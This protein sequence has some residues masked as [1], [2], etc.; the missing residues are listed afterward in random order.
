MEPFSHPAGLCPLVLSQCC[1]P[2]CGQGISLGRMEA[3]GLVSL[4]CHSQWVASPSEI[5]V[6][7]E[8]CCEL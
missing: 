7:S 4:D 3:A 8:L 5:K 1:W 6:I 2:G